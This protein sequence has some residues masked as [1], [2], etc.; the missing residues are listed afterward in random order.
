MIEQSLVLYD[1]MRISIQE[2]ARIDEA[3]EIRDQA[4]VL[5]YYARQRDDQQLDIWMSEIRLRAVIRIEEVSRGLEKS[6]G[7]SSPEA[8][9]PA[10]GESKEQQLSEAGLS[11]STA[12]RYEEVR[13]L[14]L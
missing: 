4:E 14:V 5:A 2:C 3:R 6:R 8:T 9:L 12:N 1:R 10:G 11:T 13:A 7:G